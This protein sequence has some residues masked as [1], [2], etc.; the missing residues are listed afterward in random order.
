[1]LFAKLTIIALFGLASAIPTPNDGGKGNGDTTSTSCSGS[2]STVCCDKSGKNCEVKDSCSNS[3]LILCGNTISLPGV[4]SRDLAR[5]MKRTDGKGNN[6]DKTT[7]SCSGDQST[8]C[9]NKSG[10][11]CQVS[12]SCSNDQTIICGNIL[13]LSGLGIG[14]RNDGG[15][16]DKTSTSCSGNQS[17][18]CCDQSGKD[19]SVKD[20]CSNTQTIFCGNTISIPVTTD[21]GSIL[22]RTDDKGNNGNGDNTNTKCS[23]NQSTMCCDNSGKNCSVKD[24]CNNNQV[25][26]CG[27][28]VTV[29]VTVDAGD[30]TCLLSSSC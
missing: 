5:I 11:D 26:I 20:S 30:V 18:M 4:L 2:Q 16:G 19:C 14:K 3:Q 28:T 22:R 15:D 9:C 7:T 12:S 29:P 23:G 27:N 1:M 6:G 13:D 17:T 10:K 25:I 21:L 8:M 24:S